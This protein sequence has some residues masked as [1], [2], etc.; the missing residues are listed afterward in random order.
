MKGSIKKVKQPKNK[1]WFAE[2]RFNLCKA[3]KYFPQKFLKVGHLE[4]TNVIAFLL[5]EVGIRNVT[6]R[7]L[8]SVPDLL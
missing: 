1:A 2:K 3:L 8:E 7:R 5:S 4:P 6:P